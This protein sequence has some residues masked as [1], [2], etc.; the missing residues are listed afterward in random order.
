MIMVDSEK[1]MNELARRL[2]RNLY[3]CMGFN[4]P[5]K[6]T[7]LSQKSGVSTAVISRIKNDWQGKEK[8]KL[9]TVVKLATALNVDSVDLL[10]NESIFEKLEVRA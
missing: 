10:S 7:D 4:K 9:E 2:S 3:L 6:I 5:I 1:Q 8:V